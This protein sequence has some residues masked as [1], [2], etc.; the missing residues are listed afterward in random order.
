MT[1]YLNTLVDESLVKNMNIVML[2]VKNDEPKW[3]KAL[4]AEAWQAAFEDVKVSDLVRR[5]QVREKIQ[6]KLRRSRNM[7]SLG[8]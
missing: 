2:T 1:K 6:K 8:Y 7:N 4:L 5:G 3:E